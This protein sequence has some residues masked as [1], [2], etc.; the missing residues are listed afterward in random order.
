MFTKLSDDH[1]NIFM[2]L[3]QGCKLRSEEKS[4]GTLQDLW[5]LYSIQSVVSLRNVVNVQKHDSV[6]QVQ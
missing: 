6:S 2:Q 3:M 5:K 1:L 4:L